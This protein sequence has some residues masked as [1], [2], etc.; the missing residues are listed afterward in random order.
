MDNVVRY[1][2][3]VTPLV[4]R[5]IDRFLYFSCNGLKL[6][7]HDTKEYFEFAIVT[8]II[9]TVARIL[10]RWKVLARNSI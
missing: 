8:D 7:L 1:L 9:P 4:L 3:S 2:V 10:T 5:L 6:S